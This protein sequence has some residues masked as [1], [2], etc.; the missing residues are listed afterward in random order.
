M[1][2]HRLIIIGLIVLLIVAGIYIAVLRVQAYNEGQAEESYKKGIQFG[3]EMSIKQL[4]SEMEGCKPVPVHADNLTIN[5]IAVEC[6]E[7]QQPMPTPE[8]LAEQYAEEQA[9]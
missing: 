4:L 6:L 2:Y 5:V 9:E 8:E 3:Y 7:Q 1:K